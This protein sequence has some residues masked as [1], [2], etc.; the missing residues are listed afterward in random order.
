MQKLQLERIELREIELPLKSA[1]ETSFGVTTKRRVALVRV[2][3][4]SGAAGFGEC[5][6]MEQP[7]YNPES[8]DTAWS[9]ILGNVVPMLA[10][11]GVSQ[12]VDVEDALSAIKGNRMAIAAVETAIWDLEAKMLDKPLWKHLG[13]TI[14]EIDCGVSIGLQESPAKLVEVVTREIASG[15]QRIKLKI[16]P[17]KDVAYVE[18]VRNAFPEIRLSVDANSAYRLE[19]DV[20]TMLELD[21]F[22]LLMIEQPLAAGDLLDHS[23]LQSKLT[24]PICL[25]ESIICLRDAQ[26]ALEMDACRIINVKLG[27]VGGHKAAREIQELAR[28]KGIPVW[29][30]G[31]LETGIGR[32]HNIAM[33]TLAG[34]TLP[35][36]VSASSRYWHQDIVEPPVT[37][38]EGGTIKVPDI[39]GIGYAAN[40]AFIQELTTR[41]A[42]ASL[43]TIGV[44]A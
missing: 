21:K 43:K 24:T 17:G 14:G 23:K 32:A 40:E 30:G 35:G 13:G 8:V 9:V 4:A 10:S 25:D 7:L 42:D 28:S 15:Y 34:F 22:K 29:C 38:S 3:D 44:G 18:A 11:T 5:T 39:P 31:M 6:A 12:A 20:D 27:R 37:V 36:D 1:F 41:R 26:H 16:K 33:S 2:V 19:Q